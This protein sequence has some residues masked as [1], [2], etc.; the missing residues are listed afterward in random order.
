MLKIPC[1]SLSSL[2][3]RSDVTSFVF[4]N[5]Y[6]KY[7]EEDTMENLMK[8]PPGYVKQV[9]KQTTAQEEQVKE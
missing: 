8:A 6:V 2:D 4:Q 1:L 3:S 7:K 9:N 5:E